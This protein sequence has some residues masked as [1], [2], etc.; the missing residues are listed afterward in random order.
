MEPVIEKTWELLGRSYEH[1][2]A[3][4]LQDPW[5]E[6]KVDQNLGRLV[7]TYILQGLRNGVDVGHYA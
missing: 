1:A 4:T 7:R 3:T 6:L 2:V 5:D